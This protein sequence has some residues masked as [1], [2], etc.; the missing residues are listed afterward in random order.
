ML[1]DRRVCRGRVVTRSL[2]LLATQTRAVGI[3]GAER[4][5]RVDK[6]QRKYDNRDRK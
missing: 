5:H 1:R 3:G 6:H 4:Q 2:R